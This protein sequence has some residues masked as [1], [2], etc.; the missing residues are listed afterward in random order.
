MHKLFFTLLLFFAFGTSTFAVGTPAAGKGPLVA[1]PTA[2]AQRLIA[3]LAPQEFVELTGQRM[4]FFQRLGYNKM[5]K[6]YA[7]QLTARG[8]QNDYD[9][10]YLADG[11]TELGFLLR[12]GNGHFVYKKQGEPGLQTVAVEQVGHWG[13]SQ[14]LLADSTT[15]GKLPFEKD[16]TKA[17]WFGLG[18][19]GSLLI[20]FAASGVG[21]IVL[22]ALGIIFGIRALKKIRQSDGKLRGKARAW[23]GIGVGLLILAALIAAI[24]TLYAL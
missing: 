17:M 22:G 14:T 20:P 3:C 23:V 12:Q 16:A 4:N 18:A 1:E 5:R 10:L 2:M 7:R 15:N 11:R 8:L 13:L 9:T 19:I 6:R 24:A 21:L